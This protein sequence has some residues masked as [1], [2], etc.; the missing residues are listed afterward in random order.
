MKVSAFLVSVVVTSLCAAQVGSAVPTST[1][2]SIRSFFKRD[3]VVFQDCGDDGDPK[4]MKAVNAWDEAAELALFTIE[5]QLD[6]GT[7]LQGSNA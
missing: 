4:R 3:Q 6:D 2:D 1:N 5:G 7:K